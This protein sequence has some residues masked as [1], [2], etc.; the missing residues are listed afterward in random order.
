M[1]RFQRRMA[2][3][4]S[5]LAAVLCFSCSNTF[6]EPLP[7]DSTNVDDLLTLS[8]RVC[9]QVSDPNQFPVKVL[10]IVDQSGSM[11]ISDPPGSQGSNGLCEHYCAIAQANAA[12]AGYSYGAF[13]SAV[14]GCAS[15]SAKPGRVLA[16][17]QLIDQLKGQSNVQISIVPFETTIHATW[18]DTGFAPASGGTTPV[19]DYIDALQSSLGKG[20]DYQGALDV[21][22]QI[23]HNDITT[24]NA[25]TPEQLPRTKYVIVFLTDGTPYPRCT[26]DNSLPPQSYANWDPFDPIQALPWQ[27]D[28][29]SFCT[30]DG[31]QVIPGQTVGG[32]AGAPQVLGYTLGTD[33]NQDYQLYDLVDQIMQLKNQFNVGD[34]RLHTVL[35]LNQLSVQ[36][37][38][39]ICQ[40]IY[41]VYPNI[42][43]SQ[44][45]AAT[46]A[47]ATVL[48]QHFAMQGNGT[49][50]L[51]L[52][53]DI[54]KLTLA[55]LDY[56]SLASRNVMKSFFVQ[57]LS[58]IPT[59]AGRD[60]DSDGDGLP[61][62][63]DNSFTAKTNPFNM[64]TDG[65]CLGD[66][67]EYQRQNLG[68]QPNVPDSRGKA[69]GCSCRDTDGDGLSECEELFLGTF[70]GIPDSDADG[71]PDGL[72]LRYGFN[73][74]KH[75]FFAKQDT[76]GDG[77]SDW[78]EFNANTDPTKPDAA[79]FNTAGYQ[80]SIK[81]EDQGNGSVCYD[82][83][84]SNLKMLAT[85]A[86]A[87]QRDG[88]NLFKIY[89]DEAPES[90][91]DRDYGVW[92]AACAWG[93]YAPPSVR[94][95]AGPGLDLT[96]ANWYSLQ[97]L[98]T[99]SDYKKKCVGISP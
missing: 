30:R 58:S 37:C 76:D 57:S 42:P 67:F 60:Y 45:P 8:G 96:T 13:L 78:D 24:T 9:T 90:A 83:V 51:F 38:G 20:T 21:A 2:A 18:P 49:F 77:I 12:D 69:S 29:D 92:H 47:A 63:L 40:D 86:Q 65:D 26:T 88:Y 50:E 62:S 91:L 36:L 82:Y 75:D 55:G 25:S 99:S 79:L 95:P 68:F 23:I 6:L 1:K 39:A 14:P 94:Q 87:G 52:N 35:L 31:N 10:F 80:Y 15:A 71:I 85:P 89:F 81:S 34:I 32:G 22:H 33:R 84:V 72:E 16:L 74:L 59:P 44:Y 4:S 43:A 93:E 7:K 70:P 3:A 27:N 56:T 53:Q 98:I 46:Q 5:V 41:G 28:P 64:D 11:C 97:N 17:H 19:D 73:P 61:D 54:S 66:L 48:L